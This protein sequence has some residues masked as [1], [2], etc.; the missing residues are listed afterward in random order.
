MTA[1][2]A[3]Y[4]IDALNIFESPCHSL[5]TPTATLPEIVKWGFVAID[6]IKVRTKFEVRSLPV[7]AVAVMVCGR[8][9][10]GSDRLRVRLNV[11]ISC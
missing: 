1:R 6:P 11:Y 8:H 9:G 4:M 3:L 2:C 7:V 10:I 5:V